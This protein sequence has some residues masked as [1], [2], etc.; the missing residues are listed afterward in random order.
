MEAILK[1]D[2]REGALALGQAPEKECGPG[3]VVIRPLRGACN[4]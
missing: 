2:A 3:D 1:T 4:W